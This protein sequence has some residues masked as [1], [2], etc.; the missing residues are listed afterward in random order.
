MIKK[1]REGVSSRIRVC[2]F[3]ASDF[4]AHEE[5]SVFLLGGFAANS[6]L[7][8]KLESRLRFMHIRLIR[9]DLLLYELFKFLAD[10]PSDYHVLEIELLP[11]ARCHSTSTTT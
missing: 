10:Y 5:Q 7:F 2:R 4:L 6:W 9:P 8:D 11:K 3:S 1:K